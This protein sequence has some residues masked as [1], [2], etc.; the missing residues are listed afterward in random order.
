MSADLTPW[1]IDDEPSRPERFRAL[2]PAAGWCVVY[3]WF[4]KDDQIELWWEPIVA[5]AIRGDPDAEADDTVVAMVREEPGAVELVAADS[6]IMARPHG[7]FTEAERQ[8]ETT[9]AALRTAARTRLV[10]ER[11]EQ[12]R[13]DQE[14]SVVH[15]FVTAQPDP[16]TFA[17]RMRNAGARSCHHAF[18]AITLGDGDASRAIEQARRKP[19]QLETELRQRG[20]SCR[21]A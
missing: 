17:A 1:R 3:T 5:W 15:A 18:L 4:T 11:T 13:Q 6:P 19:Y 16:A 10:R 20:S 12:A 2:M 9:L 14:Q 7:L 21:T 8:D